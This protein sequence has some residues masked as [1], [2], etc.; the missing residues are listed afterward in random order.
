MRFRTMWRGKNHNC[1]GFALEQHSPWTLSVVWCEIKYSCHF[2]QGETSQTSLKFL[3]GFEIHSSKSFFAR[4]WARNE[5]LEYRDQEVQMK[6]STIALRNKSINLKAVVQQCWKAVAQQCWKTGG[7][8]CWKAGAQQC[9]KAGENRWR[10]RWLVKTRK[11]MKTFEEV[12]MAGEN[13]KA[14]ENRWRF[15]VLV[16]TRKLNNRHCDNE[17]S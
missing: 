10:F 16:K 7:Q 9:W 2:V 12:P 13:Q 3:G 8:Q 15:Q 17:V 1:G 6:F 5:T 14:G 4:I 11:L